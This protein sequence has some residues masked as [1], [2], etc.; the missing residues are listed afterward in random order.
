MSVWS[1][2]KGVFVGPQGILGEPV[3]ELAEDEQKRFDAM[4]ADPRYAE[5]DDAALRIIAKN[6]LLLPGAFE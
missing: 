1:A 3:L 4:R 6:P 5:A 2:I